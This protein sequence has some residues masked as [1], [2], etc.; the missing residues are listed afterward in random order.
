MNRLML[1]ESDIVTFHSYGEPENVAAKIEALQAYRRPMISTEYLARG[2]GNRF[3]TVLPLFQEHRIGAI[4]WGLV[5]G[6]TQTK[7]PW[8]SWRW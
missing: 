7:Y 4:N 2:T 1:D 6:K 8:S 3:E 5:D